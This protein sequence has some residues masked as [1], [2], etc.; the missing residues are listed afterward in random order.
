MNFLKALNYS[1]LLFASTWICSPSVWFGLIPLFLEVL[2]IFFHVSQLLLSA[3]KIP[4]PIAGH[5]SFCAVSHE[6]TRQSSLQGLD[7]L[8]LLLQLF[9]LPRV[10][11]CS[12]CL[13]STVRSRCPLNAELATGD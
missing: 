1:F 12:Q 7:Q 5:Q 10:L 6:V 13:H 3:G 11:T 2:W 8:L 4:F 9:L